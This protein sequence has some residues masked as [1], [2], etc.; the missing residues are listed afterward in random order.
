MQQPGEEGN[1]G[2]GSRTCRP[3]WHRQLALSPAGAFA[4][5][6]APMSSSPSAAPANATAG[7]TRRQRV[8]L[9][10]LTLVA[11]LLRC[12]RLELWSWHEGEAATWRALTQPLGALFGSGDA[13]APLGVLA[14]RAVHGSG[15]WPGF[16]EGWLRLPVAFVGA[17]AVPLLAVALRPR[18][19]FGVASLAAALLAVHPGHLAASQTLHPA[20][21]AVACAL[22][23]ALLPPGDRPWPRVAALVAA[24]LCTP[25]AW[26]HAI[27]ARCGGLAARWPGLVLAV[28]LAA[29][30]FGLGSVGLPLLSAA[31]VGLLA[32]PDARLRLGVVLPFA[33]A[34]LAGLVA[35]AQRTAVMAVALPGLAAA[36]AVGLLHLAAALRTRLRGTTAAITVGALTPAMLVGTAGAVDAFLY[37]TVYRGA[38]TPW[39]GAADVVV[40]AANEA[41]GFVVAAAAGAPVLT[42]YLR[43][44]H[45]RGAA[46]DAHPGREVVPF[47]PADA[48]ASFDRLA[49]GAGGPCFLVLRRDEQAALSTA[50]QQR[51]ATEFVLVRVLASPQPHG[52]D[53]VYVHRRDPAR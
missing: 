39:R 2:A 44:N 22:L 43:P 16:G 53:S 25:A 5:L 31:G 40:A 47:D 33:A 35:P 1:A 30:P 46:V 38:R 34:V 21:L 37:L 7:W 9:A 28:A 15:L 11:T 13:V 41:N 23:A 32:L 6:V 17:L 36:A 3:R 8:G 19:G 42:T 50:L 12:W 4:T 26:S 29:L 45:W 14:L 49:A 10:A 51:L 52:D 20:G 18:F 24:G 27:A 48:A